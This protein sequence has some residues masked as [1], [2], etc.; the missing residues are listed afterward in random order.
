MSAAA[1]AI[2]LALAGLSLA[3]AFWE[4]ALCL[5]LLTTGTAMNFGLANTTVQERAPGP[6]RG[7]VSALAM[8]SFVGVMPFASLAMT[9]LADYAGMRWAMDAGAAAYGIA[10]FFILTNAGRASL[11]LPGMQDAG[12]QMQPE[13]ESAHPR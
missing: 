5:I 13:P 12:C 8:L 3:R 7:R 1:A 4:A 6:L 10:A 9:G 11:Q 2:V